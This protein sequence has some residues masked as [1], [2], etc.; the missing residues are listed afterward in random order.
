MTSKRQSGHSKSISAYVMVIC[1]FLNERETEYNMRPQSF[2]AVF[3]TAIINSEIQLIWCYP[4]CF[5]CPSKRSLEPWRSYVVQFPRSF[6]KAP[7][8][9]YLTVWI[10]NQMFSSH[11]N[12]TNIRGRCGIAEIAKKYP[13]GEWLHWL[14]N[15][16]SEDGDGY[17]NVT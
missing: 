15:L 2:S 14:G 10:I 3:Q 5:C 17:E 6:R 7:Y 4:P 8:I 12:R 16:S 9:N 11:S 1:H 13:S